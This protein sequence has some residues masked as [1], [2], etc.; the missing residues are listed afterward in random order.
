MK[1]FSLSVLLPVL[2][3]IASAATLNARNSGDPC[4]L[5]DDAPAGTFGFW[6][7]PNSGNNAVNCL[8]LSKK[9]RDINEAEQ[10]NYIDRR[11][12]SGDPCSILDTRPKDTFAL[13][14]CPNSG[15]GAV[16]CTKAK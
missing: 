10:L 16:R 11:Q 5:L 6:T 4:N 14:T 7:C 1:A 8:K 13:W 2:A 3:S 9:R 12:N 15:P